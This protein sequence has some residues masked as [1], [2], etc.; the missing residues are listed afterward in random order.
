MSDHALGVIGCGNMASAMLAGAVRAGVL[1]PAEVVAS[2]V[3][4]GRRQSFADA[5]NVA[6]TADNDVPA[7]CARLLLAVKPQIIGQVLDEI[8]EAL[9]ADAAVL[10][11]AAGVTSAFI[12]QHLGGR[13]HILRAMPNTPMLVGV[14][15][16]ALA[17]GP[18]ASE[19]DLAW[20]EQLLGA[21]GLA[22]RVSESALDAVTAVSGSG[23]AYVFYLAEA[24]VAAGEAEGLDGELARQLA[25]QTCMGAGAML[26]ETGEPPETLRQKVTS[27]GGTTQRA[28]ET[29]DA[30]GAA[31]TLIQAIRAAAERSRQLG[32]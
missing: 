5:L 4:A 15:A 31:E 11:I 27:P 13:G 28:I 9:P 23:P 25:A 1:A 8:A 22:V 21:S 7:G 2:D 30:A 19:E 6:T 16:S 24:M 18:R 32:T 17:A 14:G 12:D 10:S 20:A 26:L 3:D 29:L